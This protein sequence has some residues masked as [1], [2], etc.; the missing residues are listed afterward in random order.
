[1]GS[2]HLSKE[3]LQVQ[4][5][6]YYVGRYGQPFR[7]SRASDCFEVICLHDIG[8]HDRLRDQA[9]VC[10]DLG[11]D[12]HAD[13][14]SHQCTCPRDCLALRRRLTLHLSLMKMVRFDISMDWVEN[15]RPLKAKGI[16][17]PKIAI[18]QVRL[19]SHSP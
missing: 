15:A 8:G 4:H 6:V 18:K 3:A 11:L 5:P 14:M 1:M 19:D 12:F 7:G 9:E 2:E 16:M 10:L 17:F 13:H